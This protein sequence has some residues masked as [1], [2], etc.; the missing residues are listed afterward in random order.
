MQPRKT[1]KRI[2]R[3]KPLRLLIVDDSAHVRTALA[4]FCS[5]LA[6]LEVAGFSSDGLEAL[7]AIRTLKPDLVTL[8]IHMP[9]MNGLQ[10]LEVIR[11]ERC[12]CRV[13]VLSSNLDEFSRRKCL[14]LGARYAS[15]K[16][17]ELHELTQLLR[18]LAGLRNS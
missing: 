14:E 3:R 6:G 5:S 13:I 11:Q 16:T 15:N 1:G 17:T 10:V 7:A 18:K 8:D 4:Q 9:N 12:D 2:R